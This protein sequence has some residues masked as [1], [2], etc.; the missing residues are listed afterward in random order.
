M[1]TKYEPLLVRGMHGL[2]DNIHQRAFIR[3]LIEYRDVYLETSWPCIYHDLIDSG[4]LHF[5][6][7]RV[8]LRTQ[9]KN[10]T[11]ERGKFVPHPGP[12]T[13]AIRPSYNGG[14]VRK[15]PN[16]TI[17]EAMFDTMRPVGGLDIAK[18]DFRLPIPE[19][20]HAKADH[21]L[22]LMKPDK[23]ICIYRPLV[24]RPEWRGAERRNAD[25][26]AYTEIFA[27][28][29]DRF[30]VI[31]IADLEPQREWIIGPRLRA[32]QEYHKGELDFE[33]LAALF[34]RAA[35]VYT[36]SGFATLLAQ[37]TETPNISVIGLYEK[38][39]H[40]FGGKDYAPHLAIEPIRPCDCQYSY[41]NWR[42]CSKQIDIPLAIA[43][44]REFVNGLANIGVSANAETRPFGEIY[45]G[46]DPTLIPRLPA[47][48]LVRPPYLADPE[49]N[50]AQRVRAALVARQE[51]ATARHRI[52]QQQ[53]LKA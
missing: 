2:G 43:R 20:W 22:R 19:A 8:L 39:C 47:K 9:N 23:P 32:D 41:C 14:Q 35:L 40:H 45:D 10:I 34:K 16:Q 4:R 11:R 21:Y 26:K 37:A 3:Q 27:S 44:T 15:M 42:H 1:D 51:R 53:G 13:Q 5:C 33:T 12:S 31:S 36:S 29:R 46:P 52:L 18:A 24:V 17:L 6:T 28:I 30:Y 7:R 25:P 38:A 49:E 48:R 50:R